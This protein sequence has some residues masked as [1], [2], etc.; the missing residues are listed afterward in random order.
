MTYRSGAPK[1]QQ[2]KA[3][4]TQGGERCKAWAVRGATVCNAHGG[5]APSV[6]DK[7]RQRLEEAV[8]PA[9]AQLRRLVDSADSDASKLRAIENVLD[10]T[11]YK[12]PVQIEADNAV[13]IRVEYEPVEV[14]QARVIEHTIE[15]LQNGA[16]NGT[17]TKD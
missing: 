8:L 6:R 4:R 13:T 17:R 14:A 16:T 5:A 10:R 15:Q 7:A 11:G 3:H 12:L 2:C 1:S 9:L